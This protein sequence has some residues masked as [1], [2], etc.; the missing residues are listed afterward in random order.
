MGKNIIFYTKCEKIKPIFGF[1][2]NATAAAR[3]ASEESDGATKLLDQYM[4]FKEGMNLK[5]KNIY[6]S[7][8]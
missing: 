3:T 4:N 5:S 1:A 2:R 7:R 6:K 8:I